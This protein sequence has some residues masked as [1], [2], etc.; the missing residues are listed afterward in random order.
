MPA[1]LFDFTGRLVLSK[2]LEPGKNSLEVSV[3]KNGIYF[4]RLYTTE[5]SPTLKLVKE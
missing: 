1:K 5:H 2:K 4:L 3:H